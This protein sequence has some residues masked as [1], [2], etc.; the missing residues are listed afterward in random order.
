MIEWWERNY[1][2][3]YVF[4]VSR[5]ASTPGK[6]YTGHTSKGTFW[7]VGMVC[8]YVE[9]NVPVNTTLCLGYVRYSTKVEFP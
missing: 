4:L 5:Y 7:G 9:K 8:L 6:C 1:A 3:N 2:Q